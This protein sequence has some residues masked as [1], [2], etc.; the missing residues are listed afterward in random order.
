MTN[1]TFAAAIIAFVLPAC[2]PSPAPVDMA[3][4]C[5]LPAPGSLNITGDPNENV[6][7][8][9]LW[10][11]NDQAVFLRLSYLVSVTSP[12]IQYQYEVT[13]F[14]ADGGISYEIG[15]YE[16]QSGTT[17]RLYPFMG[18]QSRLEISTMP[19]SACRPNQLLLMCPSGS[20]CGRNDLV[21]TY[22]KQ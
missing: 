13:T 10:L 22:A 14:G 7:A 4:A 8:S 17:L 5:I 20:D 21:G 2:C 1:H 16:I 15:T 3:P 6:S 9:T 12:S 18:Q 11:R 19:D